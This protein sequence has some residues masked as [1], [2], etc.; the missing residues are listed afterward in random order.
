MHHCHRVA[1][2]ACHICP[3]LW[4]IG[5]KKHPSPSTSHLQVY[6]ASSAPPVRFPNVYGV[7]MP[8]RKEF[9]ADGLTEQQVCEVLH[10]D[11]LVYQEV[12]DLLDVG[13]SL[14][15]AITCFDAACFDGHYVTGAV[16]A[17]NRLHV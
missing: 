9:V 16:V 10:A 1:C 15:P 3:A 4:R 8:S 7:D 5:A 14:N 2:A 17:V 11:G 6:L 12:Q 13:Y